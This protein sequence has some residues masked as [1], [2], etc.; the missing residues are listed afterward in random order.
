ME[1]RWLS[2][3]G[4]K[5]SRWSVMSSTCPYERPPFSKAYLAGECAFERI[6]LR[7]PEFWQA[8][9]ICLQLGEAVVAVD[10]GDQNVIL[11]DGSLIR[12]G[13]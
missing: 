13:S 11:R 9:G 2:R 6:L 8:T 4:S 7:S 5:G 10:P 1:R 12:Y 3:C